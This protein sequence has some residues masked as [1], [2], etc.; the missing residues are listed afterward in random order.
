LGAELK[1]LGFLTEL[2]IK[3]VK[4][5]ARGM[6]LREVASVLGTSHQNVSVAERR[7]RENVRAAE[8]T[9]LAYRVATAAVKIIVP[10]GTHLA[11]V[12]RFVMEECDKAG[13]RLKAD[14][15]LIFK[16][17]RF[18]KSACIEGHKLSRPILILVDKEGYLSIYPMNER[19]KYVMETVDS[20]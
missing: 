17:L 4:L 10:E 7:A 5:R 2:Q 8:D 9:I 15:T 1:R 12:P 6:S 19:V 13:V 16:M 3:V 11:D 20:L 14:F 18:S